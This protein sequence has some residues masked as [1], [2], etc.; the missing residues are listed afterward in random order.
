MEKRIEIQYNVDM[1]EIV[2][3]SIEKSAHE[4]SMEIIIEQYQKGITSGELIL[5]IEE[6][7]VYTFYGWFDITEYKLCK[8]DAIEEIRL[9]SDK[10]IVWRDKPFPSNHLTCLRGKYCDFLEN[11]TCVYAYL[12][13]Q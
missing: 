8:K 12:T 10:Q 1:K 13:N 3:N 4:C 6:D 11:N 7:R 2:G 5:N 9:V